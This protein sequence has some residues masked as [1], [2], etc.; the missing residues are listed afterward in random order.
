MGAFSHLQKRLKNLKGSRKS[1]KCV[2]FVSGKRCA[3]ARTCVSAGTKQGKTLFLEIFVCH[4][5]VRA[6]TSVVFSTCRVFRRLFFNFSF[7]F[8]FYP[9]KVDLERGEYEG[10]R[11][12]QKKSEKVGKSWKNERKMC[13]FR[14][15][16]VCAQKCARAHEI[17]V[18]AKP[19]PRLYLTSSWCAKCVHKCAKVCTC[20]HFRAKHENFVKLC[21]TT[22]F[23][24][25]FDN[26][27]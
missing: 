25:F 13:V 12:F 6:R 24:H 23:M 26:F 8:A 5:S 22:T 14:R 11:V 15:A 18:F 21:F 10:K 2:F 27:S 3:R 7:F 9:L 17:C 4:G 1:K 16:H 20:A 19:F